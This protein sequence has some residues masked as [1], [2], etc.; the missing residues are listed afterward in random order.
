ME[1]RGPSIRDEWSAEGGYAAGARGLDRGSSLFSVQ[2]PDRALF[3]EA[4]HQ[5]HGGL[6]RGWTEGELVAGRNLHGGDHLRRGHPAGRHRDGGR[7]RD[8]GELALVE[9]ADERHVDGVLLRAPVASGGSAYRCRV[10]R[11]PLRRP[12]GR[13]S[14]GVPG[15][16]PGSSHQLHHPGMGQPGHGQ[17]PDAGLRHREG[18]GARDRFRHHGFHGPGLHPF[19]ALGRPCHRPVPVRSENGDDDPA[20][21]FRGPFRRGDGGPGGKTPR[22]GCRSPGRRLDPILRSRSRVGLDADDHL[23]G[24]PGGELVGDL[25]P[26]R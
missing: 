7:A 6:L 16:V 26:G 13:L 1:R 20:G 4:G 10:C 3:P 15:A 17:D 23:R 9:H 12:S 5:V 24:L 18:R 11:N 22:T 19:G 14:K 25:V 8:R 21:L 2:Y